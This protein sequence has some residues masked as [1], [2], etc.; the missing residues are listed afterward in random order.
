MLP[1]HYNN[2]PI[3]LKYMLDDVDCDANLQS[4]SSEKSNWMTANRRI[5]YLSKFCENISN[6]RTKKNEH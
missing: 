3:K 6:L 5:G 2:Q 1:S 4:K